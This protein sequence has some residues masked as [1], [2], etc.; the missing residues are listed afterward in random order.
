M[1]LAVA[2]D[3]LHSWPSPFRAR[4]L[5]SKGLCLAYQM[6]R[7]RI[8]DS[9]CDDPIAR[10]YPPPNKYE[11]DYNDLVEDLETLLIPHRLV[12]YHCT[13]LTPREVTDVRT[14][15]LRMLSA[16]L[17]KRR[18]DHC[19]EDGHFSSADAN[20]LRSSP[21]IARTLSDQTGNR[22]GRLCYC[23]NVSTL[24]YDSGVYRLFRCW[25]GEALYLGHED[26][27][28][29]MPALRLIGS[30]KIVQCAVPFADIMD[31]V[32]PFAARFLSQLV[33]DAVEYAE[34][35]PTF[36]VFATRD[37]DPENVL[38]L[39]DF[40]DPKFAALTLWPTWDARHQPQ[41]PCHAG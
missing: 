10:T 38:E 16:D 31:F 28:H 11:A 12:A 8:H 18:I 9:V 33:A 2:M 6:E 34:P 26:G 41:V 22:T 4:A 5:A 37:L 7:Q 3:D 17:L 23:P 27:P 36:D 1:Q 21:H 24:R 39:I 20:W 35:P 13:R 25:G 40:Q 14:G 15:G 30:P 19:E 29:F 32:A